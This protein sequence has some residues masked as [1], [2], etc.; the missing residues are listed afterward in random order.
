MIRI[1]SVGESGH[2]V[3]AEGARPSLPRQ[4]RAVDVGST[5]RPAAG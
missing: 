3:R 2:D 1:G 4:R 5:A